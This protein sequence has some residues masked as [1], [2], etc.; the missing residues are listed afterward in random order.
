MTLFSG[1]FVSFHLGHFCFWEQTIHRVQP[2]WEFGG[3]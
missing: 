1:A 3:I 2:L